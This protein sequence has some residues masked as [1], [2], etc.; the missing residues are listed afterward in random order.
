[1]ISV[2]TS[3]TGSSGPDNEARH[4][5][6][7]DEAVPSRY[8]LRIGE[9]DVMV[10]SDGV[11]PLPT[12][13]LAHN[14]DPAVRSAWL[15]DMFLP[16]DAFDWSLNVVVVQSGEQ[17]ILIDAGLGLDPAGDQFGLLGTRDGPRRFGSLRPRR[18]SSAIC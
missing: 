13:M 4:S 17:T 16:S 8:A 10:I 14:A 18:P 15:N 3:E 6:E 1:M 5:H 9:I 2:A 12:K 11:L 7:P